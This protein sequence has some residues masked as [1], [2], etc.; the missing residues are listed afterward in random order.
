MKYKVQFSKGWSGMWI[1]DASN[2]I[3]AWEKARKFIFE[4]TQTIF[5]AIGEIWEL[6]ESENAVRKLDNYDEYFEANS[7]ERL[8]GKAEGEKN[9][10]KNIKKKNEIK[11]R[12]DQNEFAL[13]IAYFSDGT[14]S[15]PYIVEISDED[16]TKDALALE[17]AKQKFKNEVIQTEKILKEEKAVYKAYFSDGECSGPYIA[18]IKENDVNAL[19]TAKLKLK[20]HIEYNGLEN[21]KIKIIKI[22]EINEGNDFILNIERKQRNERRVE[23]NKK[24]ERKNRVIE[25]VS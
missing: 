24:Q 13:Y 5:V 6:D 11:N 9:K 23:K 21:K 22:E 20:Q 19:E 4:H 2:D 7:K 16:R 15:E 25:K 10:N 1:F 8:D 3:R 14:C 12:D 17:T 18:E